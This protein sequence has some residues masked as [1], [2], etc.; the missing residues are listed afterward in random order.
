MVAKY[1][2]KGKGRTGPVEY[3]LDKKRVESGEAVLLRGDSYLTKQLIKTNNNK[4]KYRSGVLAFTEQNIDKKILNEIMDSFEKNTFAGL[5][6]SQYNILWVQHK[7]KDKTELHFVIPRIELSTGKAY[8]PHWHTADQKRLMLWQDIINHKYKLSSP[9]EQER[10]N[11]IYNLNTNWKNQKINKAEIHEVIMEGVA[12]GQLNN[13]NS[14]VEF[15]EISGFEIKRDKKGNLPKDYIGIRH[16]GDAKYP[17]LK[18]P[19][20]AESFTDTDQ[21]EKQ[22]S[23]RE[24]EHSFAT[25]TEFEAAQVRL[26]S[27]IARKSEYNSRI[28]QTPTIQNNNINIKLD[29]TSTSTTNII[30][31]QSINA[32]TNIRPEKVAS[33][34]RVPILVQKKQI[35]KN[36]QSPPQNTKKQETTP[37]HIHQNT[38]GLNNDTARRNIQIS[39]DRSRKKE[40]EFNEKLRELRERLQVQS[41]R[42]SQELRASIA[43]ASISAADTQQQCIREA[44]RADSN[45]FRIITRI[46]NFGA[47]IRKFGT[48]FI[49]K[50]TVKEDAPLDF[51]AIIAQN[52]DFVKRHIDEE[53]AN[54]IDVDTKEPIIDTTIDKK[55]ISSVTN[56]NISSG[57]KLG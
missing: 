19:Y 7:D 17:R 5:D 47:K 49:K 50:L 37:N 40:R 34:P 1:F 8:N 22:L 24:R 43:K 11:S 36:K 31:K 23:K 51:T 33:S 12:S 46:V 41:D 29:H 2:N 39:I 3:V 48:N 13:R 55:K 30:N 52:E 42:Y 15:L 6:K 20:Y 45:K 26:N 28:Y 14:I 18:G 4:L 10:A 38:K 35:H 21:I 57:L 32:E 54:I 25:P 16:K 53:P 27:Y 44:E 56:Q 9:Y